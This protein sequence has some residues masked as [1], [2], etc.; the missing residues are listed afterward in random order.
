MLPKKR[1]KKEENRVKADRATDLKI[2]P[3][4]IKG[5]KI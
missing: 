2:F 3:Q 5:K 4:T 1:H